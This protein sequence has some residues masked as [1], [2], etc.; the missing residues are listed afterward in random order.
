MPR[1][2]QTSR[3][4]RVA[5]GARRLLEAGRRLGSR[6]AQDDAFD[7]AASQ[8]ARGRRGFPGRLGSQAMV[9]DQRHDPAAQPGRPFVRQ[10]G[11]AQRVAAAGNGDGQFG[12]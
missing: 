9:D 8:Q 4:S 1:S 6:P 7:P 11:E 12:S 5:G 2:R 3:S 10:E